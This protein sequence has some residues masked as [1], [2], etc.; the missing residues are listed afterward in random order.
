MLVNSGITH[1]DASC[2][3][4]AAHAVAVIALGYKVHRISVQGNGD[5]EV[6]HEP[7]SDPTHKACVAIAGIRGERIRWPHLSWAHVRDCAHGDYEKFETALASSPCTESEVRERT[8]KLLRHS[9]RHVLR[10]AERLDEC[11]YL[12]SA[13]IETLWEDMA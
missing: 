7:I 8:D 10:L 12:D 2:V 4:E 6:S 5:G 1:H 11:R 9:W 13:D 3:H